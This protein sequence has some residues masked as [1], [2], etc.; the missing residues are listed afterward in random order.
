MVVK[1][2]L[3]SQRRWLR[4]GG[5]HRIPLVRAGVRFIDGAQAESRS[6]A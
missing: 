2:L 6:A 5:A 4:V 1:L 3:M